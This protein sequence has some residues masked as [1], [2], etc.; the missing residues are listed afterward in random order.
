ME[1]HGAVVNRLHTVSTAFKLT[2]ISL[3]GCT[4]SEAGVPGP[5]WAEWSRLTPLSLHG[6]LS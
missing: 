3:G 4:W 2:S 1:R 5:G 6:K